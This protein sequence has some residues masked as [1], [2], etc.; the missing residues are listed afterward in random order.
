M[1]MHT[2]SDELYRRH[3]RE[4]AELRSAVEAQESNRK[5]EEKVAAAPVSPADYSKVPAYQ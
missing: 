4:W 5:Q 2:V 3:E 1:G